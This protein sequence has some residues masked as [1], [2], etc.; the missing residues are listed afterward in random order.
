M[1]PGRPATPSAWT[2]E[3]AVQ[4][5]DQED[6]AGQVNL[7]PVVQRH[8]PRSPGIVRSARQLEGTQEEAVAVPTHPQHPACSVDTHTMETTLTVM[9]MVH[10]THR[11]AHLGHLVDMALLTFRH[12]YQVLMTPS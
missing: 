7:A 10:L 5:S 6:S 9:A 8:P 11:E 12:R 1:N 3:G 2:R 4:R